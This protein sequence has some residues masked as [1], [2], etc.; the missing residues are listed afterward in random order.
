MWTAKSPAENG[1][2]PAPSRL[3]HAAPTLAV[4]A[5]RARGG[6]G[7]RDALPSPIPAPAPT[8]RQRLHLPVLLPGGPAGLAR[9]AEAVPP[10]LLLSLL[11]GSA[12]LGAGRRGGGRWQKTVRLSVQQRRRD[13]QFARHRLRRGSGGWGGDGRA[14]GERKTAPSRGRGGGSRQ[15]GKAP[16]RGAAIALRGRC[17]RRLQLSAVP[18]AAPFSVQSPRRLLLL[19]PHLLGGQRTRWVSGSGN[20][21]TRG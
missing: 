11:L 6:G 20:A 1:K 5:P 21:V 16:R 15:S 8:S 19:S 17:R 7:G 18:A 10:P 12:R 9:P 3:A 4:S 13:Q 14:P 2:P